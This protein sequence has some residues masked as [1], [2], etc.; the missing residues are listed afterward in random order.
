M[1]PKAGKSKLEELAFC[2]GLLAAKPH[3]RRAKRR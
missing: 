2:K 1:F 3:H